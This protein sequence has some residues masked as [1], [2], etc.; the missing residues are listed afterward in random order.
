MGISPWFGT[1][2]AYPI[3]GHMS[4][5]RLVGRQLATHHTGALSRGARPSSIATLVV[6]LM[7]VGVS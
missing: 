5:P 7:A 2:S 1:R 3:L 6:H 4:R